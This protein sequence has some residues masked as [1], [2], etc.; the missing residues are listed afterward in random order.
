[1][2]QMSGIKPAAEIRKFDDRIKIILIMAFM[3]EGLLI[4]KTYE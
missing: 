4:S 2:P 1:M 3:G